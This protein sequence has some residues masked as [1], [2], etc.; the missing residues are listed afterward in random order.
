[1]VVPILDSIF[2]KY[3][4]GYSALLLTGRSLQD[5]V[6]DASSMKLRTILEV[7][8]SELRERYG[9]VFLRYSL[10]A[11]LDWD[12]ERIGDQQDRRTIETALQ[13]HGLVN[14]PVDQNE[15]V[16]VIRGIYSLSRTPTTGLKWAN[17]QDMRFSSLLE[18]GEHL[19]PGQLTNG[20]Q[21]EAQLVAIELAHLLGNNFAL[22]ASGNLVM[23]HARDGL[24]DELVGRAFQRVRLLQPGLEEKLGFLRVA[25][26]LYPQAKFENGLTTESVARLTLN[27]PN[28]GIEARMRASQRTGR[29]IGSKELAEQKNDDVIEISE[30]TLSVLDNSRIR[31]LDLCGA[32]MAKP[33]A[34]LEKFSASLLEGDRNLPLN[35]LLVGPPGTG[36][37]DLAILIADLAKVAAYQ[38]HSPKGGIVGET[39]RKSRLQW[40]ALNEWGGI[41]FCDE[42]TEALP[43]ERTE[44]DGDSGASRAITAALLTELSNGA[45]RGRR[46]LVATT[47]CPWR[48]GAAMRSRFT[49]IP[50][51][52]PLQRDFA[53]I[54]VSIAHRIVPELKLDPHDPKIQEAAKIFYEKGA[55]PREIETLL[56]NSTIML[57]EFTTDTILF[58]ARDMCTSADLAS[59]IY[60]DLWAIRT[61]TARSFFPWNDDPT[62]YLF[63]AHLEGVV[64]RKSGVVD[65]AEIEKRIEAYKPNAKV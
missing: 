39:E 19:T 47:N 15:S 37:T 20:T 44:F 2:Q 49:R 52:H 32:N 24:I 27:T 50:V 3:D 23:I 54:V 11:G 58:A 46:L 16:R 62:T 21:T 7:L 17:G 60:A 38:L 61:C 48:M 57:G 26:L 1:M 59:A 43:L 13:H 55:N 53:N 9:M 63:P 41:A 12:L 30:Q 6:A 56:G 42:I 8:R 33:K 25:Q 14:I 10:A 29:S 22:R 51:L 34:L 18:F 36:K 65:T 5:L 35:I 31:S 45:A 40:S 28:L 64:D 4:E